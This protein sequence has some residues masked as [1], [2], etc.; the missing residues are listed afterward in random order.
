MENDQNGYFSIKI[1]CQKKN[2]LPSIF[3]QAVL[4]SYKTRLT[5]VT[6]ATH[7]ISPHLFSQSSKTQFWIQAFLVKPA[8]TCLHYLNSYYL[9]PFWWLIYKLVNVNPVKW[10]EV[11][12]PFLTT[13][14]FQIKELNSTKLQDQKTA[15]KNH[16][17]LCTLMNKQLEK[18]I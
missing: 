2:I 17:C 12:F 11:A 15:Y 16:L 10:N 9:F 4:S 1:F 13:I 18:E 5:W 14:F 6:P 8:P 3:Q 7:S